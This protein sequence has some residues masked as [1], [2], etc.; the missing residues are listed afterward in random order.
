MSSIVAGKILAAFAVFGIAL[1]V[2]LIYPLILSLYTDMAWS[3]VFCNYLGF[4]FMGAA[5]IAIGVFIS[6]LTEN[7]LISAVASFG[8]LFVV[9]L[10]DWMSSSVQNPIISAV[11]NAISVTARYSDFS[12]GIINVPHIIYYISVVLIFAILTVAQIEKRRWVK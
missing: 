8:A 11:V 7:L 3:T 12:V 10:M 1:A 9:Y 2:T 6:S 4:F 5:F